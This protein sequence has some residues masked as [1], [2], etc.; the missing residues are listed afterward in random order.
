MGKDSFDIVKLNG[1]NN[2]HLRKFAVQN[3][4]DF[5]GLTEALVPKA[6]ATPNEPKLTDAEKLAK[7]KAVISLSV[8]THIYS[9][10]QNAKSAL[11]I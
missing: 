10:I 4:I 2:F 8:E 9:H 3:V 5:K 7:A 6:D 11:E 1:S